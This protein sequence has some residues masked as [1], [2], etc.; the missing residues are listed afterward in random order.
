MRVCLLG[1]DAA[2]HPEWSR[3]LERLGAQV[4]PEVSGDAEE[5]IVLLSPGRDSA[6]QHVRELRGQCPM[7]ALLV[8]V[9][10]DLPLRVQLLEEG[11]DDLLPTQTPPEEI[12]SR[13]NALIDLAPEAGPWTEVGKLRLGPS[14][15]AVYLDERH[16]D[17]GEHAYRVLRKLAV[18][19]PASASRE[20]LM[21]AGWGELIDDNRLDA[22]IRRLRNALAQATS[23]RIETLRGLGY[24]LQG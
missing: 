17:L 10:A 9:N 15:V 23:P 18:A 13:L 8:L 12:I 16:L 21:T 24:R 19:A 1:G 4:K 7:A 3:R 14:R 20:A 5:A 2:T 22:Q 11:A 6:A